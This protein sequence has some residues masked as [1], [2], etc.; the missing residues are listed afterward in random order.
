MPLKLNI[1]LSKKVGLP[2]YGS[3]GASCHVELEL[4]STLLQND[5]DAFHRHVRNSFVAC[6][7]AVSDELARQNNQAGN[8]HSH[9][10]GSNGRYANGHTGNGGP[11]RNGSKSSN[12]N[13]RKA[14]QSQARAIWAIADRQGID[15]PDLLRSRFNTDRTEDLSIGEASA[16]IDELNSAGDNAGSKR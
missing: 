8:G 16:L 9:N 10:G 13:G 6:S 2:D 4:E 15:L 11:K 5:L 14:T 3:L 1:G 12:G 7:Q